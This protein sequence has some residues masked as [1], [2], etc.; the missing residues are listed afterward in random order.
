MLLATYNCL[1]IP[2]EMAYEPDFLANL[3]WFSFLIDLIFFIDIVVAARTTYIDLRTG[4]EVSE[5]KQILRY[6][7][8]GQFTIDLLATVPFDKLAELIL[9]EAKLFKLLGTLK[10][11]RI[12]RLKRIIT[13]SRVGEQMKA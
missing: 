7:L 13:Y 4:L 3:H 9:G 8:R 10:L 5:P 12:L 2:I 11:V 6:Y 1:Q